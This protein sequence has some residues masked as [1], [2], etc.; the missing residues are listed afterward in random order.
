M[1]REEAIRAIATGKKAAD[2]GR[3]I[4]LGWLAYRTCIMP[5]DAGN[6]QISETRLAFF[7]GAEY[8]Y[9]SIMNILDPEEDE[10]L[11]DMTRMQNIHNELMEFRKQLELLVQR[12]EGKA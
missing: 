12:P 7:A 10:T 8:L 6:T 1:N 11:A 4:E 2:E 3:L 9:S 5:P